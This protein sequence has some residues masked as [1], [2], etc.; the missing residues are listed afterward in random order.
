MIIN[1]IRDGKPFDSEGLDEGD[2][3]FFEVSTGEVIK[4]TDKDD[5]IKWKSDAELEGRVGHMIAA[6]REQK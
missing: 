3:V 6:K 1:L 2:I 4:I 5:K